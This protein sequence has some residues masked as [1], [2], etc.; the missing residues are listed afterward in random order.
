MKSKSPAKH[1]RGHESER[2]GIGLHPSTA[3]SPPCKAKVAPALKEALGS[4]PRGSITH[5]SRTPF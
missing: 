1:R 4:R 2:S 5:R 3:Y